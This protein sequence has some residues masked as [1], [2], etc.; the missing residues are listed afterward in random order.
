MEITEFHKRKKA[1]L[2]LSLQQGHIDAQQKQYFWIICIRLMY[3]LNEIRHQK[4]FYY[5]STHC[6]GFRKPLDA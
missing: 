5:I 2:P 4:L 6:D 1:R 3:K